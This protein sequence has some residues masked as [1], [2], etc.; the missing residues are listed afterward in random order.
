M[1]KSVTLPRISIPKPQKYGKSL[2]SP[3]STA[4]I[5]VT[6]RT[7]PTAHRIFTQTQFIDSVESFLNEALLNTSDSL[8]IYEA[9]RN[10]FDMIINNFET[11]RNDMLK[12]KTGYEKLI[13]QFRKEYKI[14]MYGKK[15]QLKSFS[16]MNSTI[17]AQQHKIDLKRTELNK[18]SDSVGMIN[19][20]IREEIEALKTQVKYESKENKIAD[21]AVNEDANV[22]RELIQKKGKKEKSREK[23]KK[24]HDDTILELENKKQQHA[25]TT[26]KLGETLDAILNYNLM[27]KNINIR[28]K[29]LKD[30]LNKQRDFLNEMMKKKIE[31]EEQLRK[32]REE[33]SLTKE[34]L[35]ECREET[36]AIKSTIIM[37]LD[38]LGLEEVEYQR[39]HSDP[40]KL[41]ALY[42]SRMKGYE[43][44]I[45]PELFPDLI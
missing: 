27:I 41:L 4:M 5:Q 31:K 43:G 21:R 17:E 20:D 6:T 39:F 7:I 10:A 34:K 44:G 9:H 13:N 26:R 28:I 38:K 35:E 36:I 32:T 8:E 33:T 29:K 25:N 3:L 40:T 18:L 30:D 11:H 16:Q 2:P 15:E 23:Y 12:V 1:L 24:I 22:L 14:A 19:L 45:N 42:I 37:G